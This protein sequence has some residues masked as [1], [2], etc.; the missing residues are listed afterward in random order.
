MVLQEKDSLD[1]DEA[2]AEELQKMDRTIDE[3]QG[4]LNKLLD[5]VKGFAVI[6]AEYEKVHD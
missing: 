1:T 6:K 5:T 2:D 4:I 3:K